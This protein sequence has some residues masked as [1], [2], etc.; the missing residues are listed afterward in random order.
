MHRDIDK[1]YIFKNQ[2]SDWKDLQV[3]VAQ[4]LNDI[5][6]DTEIEMDIDTVRGKVNIDVYA[7][8]NRENPNTIIIAECK[9]WSKN[10]PKSIVHSFRTV[11]NDYG[12]NFGFII[13]KMGFQE[14]AYEAIKKSNVQLFDWEEFQEYFKIK[15]LENIIK[16]LDRIGKPLWYF[17]TPM[18]D[19]YYEELEKLPEEKK[20]K[21][22]ELI[23][24][25]SEFSFYSNKDYY[26][27]YFT[28]EIEFLDQAIEQ[29]KD[30]LPVEINSY[31]DYF[32][33]I[34]N[35]CEEGIKQIDEIFG[36]QIRKH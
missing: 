14:G 30:T 19:F 6:F 10:V 2:P 15:W 17:T 9:N 1:Y 23:R 31:S 5:G 7:E 34:K 35:Y 3:K 20:I 13:S 28:G 8:N 29:R 24:K 33:F 22:F 32:Y 25:Y 12:A 21:F 4:I 27:N 26:L 36:K 11:I 18:Q 16:S